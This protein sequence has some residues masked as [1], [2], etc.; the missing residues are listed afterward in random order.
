MGVR[1]LAWAAVA[2]CIAVLAACSS[3]NSDATGPTNANRLAPPPA[4]VPADFTTLTGLTG[5]LRGVAVCANVGPQAA[6]CHL[7]TA[8]DQSF[9][10][11]VFGGDIAFRSAYLANLRAVDTGYVERGLA[12]VSGLTGPHWALVPIGANPGLLPTL[13]RYLGGSRIR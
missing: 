1:G 3:A 5:A 2:A 11:R 9:R 10:V 7:L 6:E 13:Q 4:T 8:S 12:P